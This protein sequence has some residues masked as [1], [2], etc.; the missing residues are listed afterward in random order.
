MSADGSWAGRKVLVTGAGGFIGS[1]LTERLV[2]LGAD[3]HAFVEYNSTGS[4]G[5][6]DESPVRDH[7]AVTHGDIRDR[8]SIRGAIRGADVVFHL[9]ALIAIPYSYQAPLSFIKTNIEGTANLLLEAHAAKV[10]RVVHTSTSEVYGTARYVPMDEAHPLQA[11]SP[12]AASKIGADKVAEAYAASF[13]LNVVTVRPFNAYG[14]RQSARAVIPTIITQVLSEP[15]VRLGSTAP[16]RD[17]NFVE[18]TVEGFVLA[19][20]ADQAVGRVVNIGSGQ[21]ISIGDLAGRVMAAVGREVPVVFDDQRFRP[22]TSEVDRLQADSSLA[23]ELIGWEPNHSLDEGLRI[24]VDWI[25][26]NL[27]VFRPGTYAV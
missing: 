25:K 19:G 15:Q 18:D 21:M 16:E 3:T 14:P 1:H 27:S 11:Q 5:W 12:Y 22:E 20:N 24:T 23:K 4:L 6:L 17:F 7:I 9:A 26:D 8:D 13:D 10:E 2:A